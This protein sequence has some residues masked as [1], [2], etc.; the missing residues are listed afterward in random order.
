MFGARGSS[1]RRKKTRFAANPEPGEDAIDREVVFEI[2]SRRTHQRKHPNVV[3]AGDRSQGAY[4][5]PAIAGDAAL[6]E[7]ADR[8]I[9]NLHTCTRSGDSSRRAVIVCSRANRSW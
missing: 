3:L 9:E 6:V 4:L 7:D 1:G 8:Q 5:V 2:V